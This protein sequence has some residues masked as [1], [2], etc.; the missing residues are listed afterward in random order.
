MK[1]GKL[2]TDAVHSLCVLVELA[3]RAGTNRRPWIDWYNRRSLMRELLLMAEIRLTSWYGKYHIIYRVL[4]I[5]GGAG[6]LPSPV[7]LTDDTTKWTSKDHNPKV[8]PTG[9]HLAKASS[10]ILSVFELISLYLA[11][12]MIS[13]LVLVLGTGHSLFRRMSMANRKLPVLYRSTPAIAWVIYPSAKMNAR[14]DANAL[15]VALAKAFFLKTYPFHNRFMPSPANFA[16][17]IAHRSSSCPTW[18]FGKAA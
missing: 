6:V 3:G 13:G 11:P 18:R 5:P 4:Y 8:F 14:L 7:W 17:R 16:W 10:I 15:D 2:L 9:N 12:F 1:L